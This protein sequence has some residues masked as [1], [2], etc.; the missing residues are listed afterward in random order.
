MAKR[1][2]PSQAATGGDTF[3]D[4]LV[5][6][7]ITDGTSQLTNTNF[8]IDRSIPERDIKTFR[9]GQ[10]SD[11]L[12]LDD[13]K[14]DKY[15]SEDETLDTRK[16]EV[17]FRVSKDDAGKS[18]FGSLKNRIGASI[19]NIIT[20]FPAG[21]L[22]D[23]NSLT[24]SSQYTIENIT[25]DI[26]L[27]DTQFEVDFGRIYNPFDVLFIRPNSQ[28]DPNTL[29]KL[30]N[31]YSSFTKYVVEIEG[32]TYDIIG[33]TEPNDNF[34]ITLKIKGNPFGTSLNYSE[35]VLIRPNNGLVE[36]FFSNLDELEQCLLDRDSNP[37]YTATFSVPK[38]SLNQSETVLSDVEVT[39]PISKD[40][41]NVKIV[42]LDY[43]LYIQ[44]LSDLAD[45]VDDYKSNLFVRFMSS[46]QLF[47]FD[48]ED[49]K[50]ESVFQL[51]GH[52]FDKVKKYIENI[53][54]M[55]HV[56]YDGINNLPDVLL[57]NLSNTLGL[58]T[59]NLFDEKKLED[60]LYNRQDTQYE[61]LTFGKTIIDA[62]YE[63]YRR[64]LV[65]LAYIYKSK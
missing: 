58:S 15:K 34:Y 46:P 35:D 17:S 43:E 29:N 33:Y 23:K 1:K 16:K 27:N 13:L 60:L 21:V 20:K 28:V 24:K 44:Q 52:N 22:I 42:G 47:E 38:D 63:F 56:S 31:F 26:N 6:R 64:L 8:A 57:K 9:T 5:G 19:S 49:K 25:Y 39:W 18:L 10:F 11:F 36:E 55:R 7:Q 4:S 65:N 37:K 53:A 40:K 50:A 32:V 30:R 54:Y 41:W 62:E 51:Y 61:G 12:T 14:D 59:V 48:T 45:E 3:S 2:V